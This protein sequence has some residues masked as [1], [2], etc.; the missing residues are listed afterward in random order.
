MTR[1][2]ENCGQSYAPRRVN[3]KYCDD[4]RAPKGGL[5]TKHRKAK[6]VCDHCGISFERPHHK[7]R[8]YCS[9]RCH[10]A[11]RDLSKFIT[12]ETKLYQRW[13]KRAAKRTAREVG[14]KPQLTRECRE[15]DSP[16]ET[17]KA[18]QVYCSPIC[19]RRASKR[20]HKQ[21]RR[22]RERS[23]FV[24][25]VDATAVF[26]RDGWTCQLCGCKTPKRRRGTQA[27]DAPELDHIVPLAAGGEHSYRNTQCACRACNYTK[28]A[29]PR[30]QLLLVG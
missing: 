28:G 14:P 26:E 22:A 9:R 3:A 7:K 2:C 21:A 30:G 17:A 11:V 4:C 15:C 25:R 5:G 8:K 18:W 24:E 10:Q 6:A 23:A 13:A 12:T 20:R 29:E 27:D 1:F 16:F 19:S